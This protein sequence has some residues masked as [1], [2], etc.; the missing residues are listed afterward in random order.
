L[1]EK[2]GKKKGTVKNRITEINNQV[3]KVASVIS[4]VKII[5]IRRET[6]YDGYHLNPELFKVT[7]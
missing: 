5:L 3:S 6:K 7:K 2:T 4:S 1:S